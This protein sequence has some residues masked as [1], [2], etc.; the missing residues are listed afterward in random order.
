MRRKQMKWVVFLL[1][2]GG[3]V[4]ILILGSVRLPYSFF[5]HFQ[6]LCPISFHFTYYIY[7]GVSG[8]TL[9]MYH[10]FSSVFFSYQIRATGCSFPVVLVPQRFEKK[11][12]AM[13]F[14]PYHFSSSVF[15]FIRSWRGL[16][17]WRDERRK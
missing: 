2:V 11:R 1:L 17:L 10:W 15:C 9:A 4:L 6:F 13:S 8:D 12:N 7:V 5:F 3:Y 16:V 14:N